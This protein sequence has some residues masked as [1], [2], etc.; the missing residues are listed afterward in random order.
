M[1]LEVLSLL[2][3]WQSLLMHSGVSGPLMITTIYLRASNAR[4]CCCFLPLAMISLMKDETHGSIQLVKLQVV[5]LTLDDLANKWPYLYISYKPLDYCVRLV[6]F[7]VKISG[8]LFSD[9]YPNI[10]H[11]HVWPYLSPSHKGW[12]P[13][14]GHILS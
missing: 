8:I 6:A 5:I 2:R 12:R 7:S 14:R 4:K 13:D 11:N 10:N 9:R 1:F 3:P